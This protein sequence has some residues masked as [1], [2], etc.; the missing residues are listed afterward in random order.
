MPEN[1]NLSQFSVD[2]LR[3]VKTNLSSD[4]DIQ[5]CPNGYLVLASDK[6]AERLEQNVALL[7]E[8]GVK[9]EL[10]TTANIQE[11]YPWI[12]TADIKLGKVNFE[13]KNFL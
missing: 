13:T 10:L 2:F 7:K 9:H 5:F 6:Y 1:I 3:N 4:V 12:N 11:K 8:H